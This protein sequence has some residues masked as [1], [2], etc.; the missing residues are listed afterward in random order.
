MYTDQMIFL[1]QLKLM[2]SNPI[3]LREN[4]NRKNKNQS[5]KQKVFKLLCMNKVTEHSLSLY[6]YI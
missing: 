3:S 2:F 1:V 6:V 5:M 4:M